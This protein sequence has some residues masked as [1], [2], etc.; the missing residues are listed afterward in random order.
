MSKSITENQ[1]LQLV[2]LLTLGIQHQKIVTQVEESIA[3]L[4]DTEVGGHLSDALYGSDKFDVDKLLELE[5]VEIK[6][7]T[8]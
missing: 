7:A 5:G 3:E 1:K 6:D 4:T 8:A 2:G